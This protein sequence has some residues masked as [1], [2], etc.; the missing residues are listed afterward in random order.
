MEFLVTLIVAAVL[1]RLVKFY[2]APSKKEA[3]LVMTGV[4]GYTPASLKGASWMWIP[5]GR[6]FSFRGYEIP[7]G[8]LY[9]G[10]RMRDFT[11][12]NEACLVDP[13]LPVAPKGTPFEKTR[14][15]FPRYDRLTP[16]QRAGFLAWMG[17]GRRVAADH[18]WL[19]LFLYGVERR[20]FVDGPRTNIP[21]REQDR[22]TAEIRELMG[23]YGEIRSFRGHCKNLLAASWASHG[24]FAEI[25]EYIDFTDRFCSS[26]FNVIFSLYVAGG[27]PIPAEVALQWIRL[28]PEHVKGTMMRRFPSEFESL[29]IDGYAQRFGEGIFIH[30]NRTSLSFVYRGA[31]PSFGNGVKL[32]VPSLPEPFLLDTP[33]KQIKTLA[34]DCAD[35]IKSGNQQGLELAAARDGD[36]DLLESLDDD[37]RELMARLAAKT[38]WPRGEFL[39]ACEELSVLPD[40]SIELINSWAFITGGLALIEDGD[41]LF[42]DMALLREIFVG[43]DQGE[44]S[45]G[46]TGRRRE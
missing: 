32:T 1:I 25:P 39:S 35:M 4:A 38:L 2:Y 23:T 5:P 11:G 41:P 31:N 28:H 27:R 46:R 22:L 17:D 15:V 34:C 30:N 33:L 26:A 45:G 16:E 24:L 29:F 37:H 12:S 13:A 42:V 20:L 44:E 3:Q 7:D 10:E 43:D 8:M 40:P 21:M 9:V 6:G 36:R 14:M 19:L 18:A